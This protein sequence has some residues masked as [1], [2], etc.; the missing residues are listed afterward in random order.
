MLAVSDNGLGAMRF[1]VENR[2]GMPRL[3][4]LLP[5]LGSAKVVRQSWIWIPKQWSQS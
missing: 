4:T 2:L 1:F 3:A 5:W